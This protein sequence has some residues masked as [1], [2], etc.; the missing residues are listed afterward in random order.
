M[1]G[2]IAGILSAG[3]FIILA[4]I[5]IWFVLKLKGG[6]G[7]RARSLLGDMRT[8]GRQLRSVGSSLKGT[9]NE[10]KAVD[11]VADPQSTAVTLEK[12]K[13]ELEER[14]TKLT[15][16]A[17]ELENDK[18]N[19]NLEHQEAVVTIRDIRNRQ[20]DLEAVSNIAARDLAKG[21]TTKA[22]REIEQ[23]EKRL[24]MQ[25]TTSMDLTSKLKTKVE[26][27]LNQRLNNAI[28]AC[29]ELEQQMREGQQATMDE[30][31][32]RM[33]ILISE[34]KAME[35]IEQQRIDLQQ[36]FFQI[37]NRIKT[38]S[39]EIA[40]TIDGAKATPTAEVAAA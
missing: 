31:N 32:Q 6:A 26:N 9:Q 7:A 14:K 21:T 35:E 19:L 3:I 17:E 4:A 38:L 2:K 28:T 11:P 16:L 39:T 36:N 23:L 30:V 40:K 1:L 15:R 27:F 13:T 10:L 33:K 22:F 8:E 25:K 37:S 20:T 18:K 29:N 5:V 34:E 24:L 12:V